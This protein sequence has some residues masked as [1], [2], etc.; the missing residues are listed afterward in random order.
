MQLDKAFEELVGTLRNSKTG[1]EARSAV[2][3]GER[4]DI[5]RGKDFVRWI[6]ANMDSLQKM[7][8][9]RGKKSNQ[10]DFSVLR[11]GTLLKH[12]DRRRSIF[13]LP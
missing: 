4:F 8:I 10:C 12:F 9:V 7:P 6:K 13:P 11:A 2:L 1:P 5:I 3:E